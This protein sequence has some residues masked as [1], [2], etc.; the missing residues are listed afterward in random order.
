[1][2]I[3]YKKIS[4]YI[5]SLVVLLVPVVYLYAAQGGGTNTTIDNPLKE[6]DINKILLNIMNIVSVVGG[7]IVV[8]FIIYSG[9]KFVTARGNPEELKNAKNIFYFTIIG[10]AILLGAN[11]IANVVV[12]TVK[13]TT[14]AGT[15]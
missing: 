10:G 4:A 11:I 8:L 13:C 6:D 9:F 1:M 5:V 3:N 12:N 14:G 15:C 7:I 2:K